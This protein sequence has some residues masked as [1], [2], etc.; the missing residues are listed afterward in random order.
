MRRTYF[1]SGSLPDRASSGHV[2]DVTSGQKALLGRIWRNF[3]L[4]MRRTYFRTWSL[5]VTWLTSLPVTWLPVAPPH[6][7]TANVTLSVPIYYSC[8]STLTHYPDSEATSLCSFSLILRA[9]HYKQQIPVDNEF[10]YIHVFK[11]SLLMCLLP[12]DC[13]SAKSWPCVAQCILY[14]YVIYC[15]LCRQQGRMQ[16]GGAHPARVPP[17]K[18]IWK[19]MIFWRK[20]VIFSH[21]IPQN[22]LRLPPLGAIF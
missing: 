2:T 21:E 9:L 22:V 16:G 19:N 10:V 15:H 8:R 5:P 3:R 17:K 11:K 13:E 14:C 4:R 18:K 20:I 1:R 7:T 12:K 6:S